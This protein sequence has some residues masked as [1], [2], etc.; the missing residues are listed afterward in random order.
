MGGREW[1]ELK[2]EVDV[3]WRLDAQY[4][5][6]PSVGVESFLSQILEDNVPEKY[7]LSKKACEG[8]L[9]SERG[10][11]KLPAQLEMA[12]KCQSGTLDRRRVLESINVNLTPSLLSKN[13]KQVEITM[14]R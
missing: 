9:R 11:G 12:L 1:L 4:W 14:S 2:A 8:I 7:F 13:G 6:V 10:K 3:A 5:G